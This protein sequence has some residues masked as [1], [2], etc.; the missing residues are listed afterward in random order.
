ML[1]VAG[2]L[3]VGL[4]LGELP[5]GAR[6]HRHEAGSTLSWP[7]RALLPATVHVAPGFAFRETG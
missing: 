1:S 7:P 4:A 2:G 5:L 3:G 6:K